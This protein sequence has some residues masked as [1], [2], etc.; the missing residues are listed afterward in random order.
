MYVHLKRNVVLLKFLHHFRAHTQQLVQLEDTDPALYLKS[1][2][3]LQKYLELIVPIHHVY[4]FVWVDSPF[5]PIPPPPR[6]NHMG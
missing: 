6:I 5:S 3:R 2:E 1:Q 4:V